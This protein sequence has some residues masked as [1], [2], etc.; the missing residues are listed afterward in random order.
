MMTKGCGCGTVSH[1]ALSS[2]DKRPPDIDAAT[3]NNHGHPMFSK[4]RE[5]PNPKHVEHIFRLGDSILVAVV[6]SYTSQ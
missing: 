3:E 6:S 5:D 1:V 2:E 4:Y